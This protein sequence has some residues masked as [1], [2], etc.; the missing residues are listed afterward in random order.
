MSRLF[1]LYS[2]YEMLTAFFESEFSTKCE[3][4]LPLSV[5][6]ILSFPSGNPVAAYVFFLVF[7]HSFILPSVLPSIT[8]F[9]RQCLRKKWLLQFAF[10]LLYLGYSVSLQSL[11]YF[12]ISHTPCPTDLLHP[13]LKPLFKTFQSFLI[14]LS[15]CL[16]FITIFSYAPNVGLY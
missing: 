9:K 15:K 3:L 2:V 8:R 7:P 13:S 6:S 11:Y 5:A 16:S 10:F 14:C 4:V 12:F 1:I